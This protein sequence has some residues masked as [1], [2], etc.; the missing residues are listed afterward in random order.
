MANFDARCTVATHRRH[1]LRRHLFKANPARHILW[2]NAQLYLF[3]SG[4]S[5]ALLPLLGVSFT[6]SFVGNLNVYS[7]ASVVVQVVY[8]L[9]MG[10]FL[11]THS[12]VSKL[13]IAATGTLL[14]SAASTWL[15]AEPWVAQTG[16]GVVLVGTSVALFNHHALW[17]V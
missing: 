9:A 17:P 11:R 6:T 7:A 4:F 2:E 10:W 3:S 13:F 5:L 15:F 1:S 16:V 12:S 8:G 14:V